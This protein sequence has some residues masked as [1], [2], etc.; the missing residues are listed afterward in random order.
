[1]WHKQFITHIILTATY[2]V[3]S[4]A[5]L[6]TV[7][8]WHT[9][10]T[11]RVIYYKFT[12]VWYSAKQGTTH[13]PT[14]HLA[15]YALSLATGTQMA[16]ELGGWFHWPLFVITT[17]NQKTLFYSESGVNNQSFTD[18]FLLEFDFF[19]WTLQQKP[20]TICLIYTPLY[21]LAQLQ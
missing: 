2:Y 20:T 9:V 18:G 11:K 17:V 16:P 10:I 15:H 21:D 5:L 12:F 3:R 7:S 4:V 14:S 19:S 13:R 1:M 8:S 6:I